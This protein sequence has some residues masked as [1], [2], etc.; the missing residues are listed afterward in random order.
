MTSEVPPALRTQQVGVPRTVD[1]ADVLRALP[2]SSSLPG[3]HSHGGLHSM[4]TATCAACNE[5]RRRQNAAA[6]PED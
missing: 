2:Y 4:P 1:T 3:W 5:L 6:Q